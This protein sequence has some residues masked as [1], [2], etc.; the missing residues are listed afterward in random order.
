MP[1]K[2]GERKAYI[3]V[4]LSLIFLCILSLL[5]LLA[6][7]AYIA[8]ERYAFQM[9]AAS[10]LDS[11]MSQYHRELWEKYRIL[12]LDLSEEEIK[13]QYQTY[14]EKNA[15]ADTEGFLLQSIQAVDEGGYWIEKEIG[16]YMKYGI[17]TLDWDEEGVQEI[18]EEIA[19]AKQL[20]QIAEK[21]ADC[22]KEA[23]KLEN[24]VRKLEKSF[25]KEN[26]YGEEAERGI[27]DKKES[28][29]EKA[30]EKYKKENASVQKLLQKYEKIA[31]T[32]RNKLEGREEA[33]EREE[34]YENWEEVSSW[35]SEEV[36]SYDSYV[37]LE[38]ERYQ[39]IVELVKQS[40][41]N[42]LM[43]QT[44]AEL[45]KQAQEAERD[46]EDEEGSEGEDVFWSEAEDAL[47]GY[48]KLEME[49]ERTEGD[50]EKAELLEQAKEWLDG[51]G[52]GLLLGKDV[53]ISESRYQGEN[54]PSSQKTE[55][56]RKKADLAILTAIQMSAYIQAYFPSY[57]DGGSKNQKTDKHSLQYEMEYVLAGENTDKENLKQAAKQ[58]WLLRSGFNLLHLYQDGQK[59]GEAEQLA[60][61]ILGSG[62]LAP[63]SPILTFFILTVWAAAEGLMDVRSLLRE[64]KVPLWKKREDWKLSLEEVL[65]LGEREARKQLEGGSGQ[66]KG[67]KGA[68]GRDYE[69]YLSLLLLLQERRE[70]VYRMMDLMQMNIQ[71]E[72]K[73][74]QISNCLYFLRMEVSGK[75]EHF[76]F[77]HRFAD[78]SF[79]LT[80]RVEKAY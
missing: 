11:V 80:A 23:L 53:A 31:E 27:Q 76:F 28:Q 56:T 8:G 2:D 3:T 60:Q 46:D 67:E 26:R 40:E 68:K 43:L 24:I 69:E 10:S 16:E 48:S 37:E 50:E 42:C 6:E 77:A 51:E 15:F 29:V 38:G 12:L 20:S 5:L 70:K 71:K 63:F 32:M 45:A 65:Q 47:S 61:I 34:S 58:I 1:E 33:K 13:E 21:Y 54:L 72:Q 66:E 41:S 52:L 4:F 75:K 78:K 36:L 7:S 9:A 64:E 22:T 74:F 30:A 79:L 14:M 59:R 44:A 49:L 57:L 39:E 55:R 73:G 19:G 62:G 25:D 35:A 18:E 17:W